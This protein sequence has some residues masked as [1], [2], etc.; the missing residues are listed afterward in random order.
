MSGGSS[1][2]Y[3]AILIFPAGNAFWHTFS[4]LLRLTWKLDGL[5]H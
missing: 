5:P 1:S 3:V 4:T 2:A